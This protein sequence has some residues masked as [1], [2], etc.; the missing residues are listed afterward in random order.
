M[1]EFIAHWLIIHPENQD[2]IVGHLSEWYYEHSGQY[3]EFVRDFVLQVFSQDR[4]KGLRAGS[5][6]DS[7]ENCI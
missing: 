3:Y 4:P 1:D 5:F 6:K 7:N 2:Y